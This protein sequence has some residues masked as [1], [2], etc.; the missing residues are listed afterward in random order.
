MRQDESVLADHAQKARG[1]NCRPSDGTPWPAPPIARRHHRR[2]SRRARRQSRQAPP[3]QRSIAAALSRTALSLPQW[4]ISRTSPMRPF[5]RLVRHR[6]HAARI[7]PMEH[8]LEGRPFR[9][10][11]A[12]VSARRETPAANICGQVSVVRRWPSVDRASSAL[13][14]GLPAP[15]RRAWCVPRRGSRKKGDRAIAGSRSCGFP[16]RCWSRAKRKMSASR[17]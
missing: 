10:D 13:A 2:A 15:P 4:R 9:I 1:R 16:D 12:C 6:P 3:P 11:Q 7:E 5:E 8:F 14:A 17:S